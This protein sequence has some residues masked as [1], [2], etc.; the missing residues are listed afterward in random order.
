MLGSDSN[1]AGIELYLSLEGKAALK[2]EE[3]IMNASGTSN[4][5]EM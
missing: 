3:V 1:R 4:V 5:G 2:G